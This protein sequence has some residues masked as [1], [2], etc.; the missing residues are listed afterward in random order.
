MIFLAAQHGGGKSTLARSEALAANGIDHVEV[1][2][3]LRARYGIEGIADPT[4]T[5]RILKAY[6]AQSPGEIWDAVV[7]EIK[8]RAALSLINGARE[9]IVV[10]PR[11]L[12]G[13]EYIRGKASFGMGNLI[14]YIDVPEQVLLER[15]NARNGSSLSAGQFSRMLGDDFADELREIRAAADYVIDG[16]ASAREVERRFI[17]I[18]RRSGYDMAA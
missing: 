10:G 5:T 3:T 13:I 8:K 4:E 15:Y 7:G 18:L 14:V 6:L 12:S 17:G 9:L 16:N 2:K 1:G 11:V